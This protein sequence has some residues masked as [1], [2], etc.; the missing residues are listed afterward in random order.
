MIECH[1]KVF[2]FIDSKMK[3]LTD[4]VIVIRILLSVEIRGDYMILS[5]LLNILS[6]FYYI[7]LNS[8][9]E[10][11]VDVYVCMYAY[12]SRAVNKYMYKNI[13]E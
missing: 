8:C 5:E 13:T 4:S 3:R 6:I 9:F 2:F 10:G 7:L 1:Q 12:F 11:R